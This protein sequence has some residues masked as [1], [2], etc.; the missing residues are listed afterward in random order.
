MTATFDALDTFRAIQSHAQV[1]G[2]YERVILHEPLN[3]P[4][5]GRTLA[6]WWVRTR[7]AGMFSGLAATSI[8]VNF[9][10]RQYVGAPKDD[11]D[12]EIFE[13]G[14]LQSTLEFENR[15]SADF[16]LNGSVFPGLDLLGIAGEGL[17]SDAG[18]VDHSGEL[19]RIVDTQI[20]LIVDDVHVQAP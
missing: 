10:A 19:Y 16:T 3:A 1:L 6:I 11:G 12:A 17:V 8:T 4:P 13:A 15:L 7:P 2:E 9:F 5:V 18:W 20:P 14:L